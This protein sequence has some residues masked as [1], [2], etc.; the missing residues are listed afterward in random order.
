M[1]QANCSAS[2]RKGYPIQWKTVM[3]CPKPAPQPIHAAARLLRAML[4]SQTSAGIPTKNI[5][6]NCAGGWATLISAPAAN[7]NRMGRE[8][9]AR[10]GRA[11][12][13]AISVIGLFGCLTIGHERGR[14]GLID[15]DAETF[16][17]ASVSI[18]HFEFM[19]VGMLDHL[20]P[21][22][23]MVR[24]FEHEPAKIGR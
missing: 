18:D 10:I 6:G 19:A 20:A 8:R 11:S 21:R 22:R 24:Q 15:R 12:A 13:G 23:D 1:S 16:D 14:Q 2:T 3:K 4:T 7:A 17:L 9:K 5:Q